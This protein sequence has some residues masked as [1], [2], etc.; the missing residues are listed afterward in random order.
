[1]NSKINN[2][3]NVK[4]VT[5]NSNSNNSNNRSTGSNQ[6]TQ[7][8]FTE[9]WIN[10]KGIQN[11]MIMLPG[12]EKVTGVKIYPRNI[13]ILDSLQQEGVLNAMRNFYNQL[14]FEF[15]MISADRP[16]DISVYQSQLQIMLQNARTPGQAKIIAQDIDKANMFVNNQVVDTEYYILFKEKNPDEIN[17][18]IR[19]LINGLAQAG[20]NSSQTSNDDLRTILDNFLNGGVR[21]E[22]GTVVLER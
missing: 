14:N 11:G 15:W 5:K 22:F 13:F 16:V 20:L 17:R 19:V 9:D 3:T 10:I 1:M 12:N 18:K 2:P 4:P 6:N 7:S 8:R 21:T